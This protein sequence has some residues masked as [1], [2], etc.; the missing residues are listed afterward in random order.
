MDLAEIKRLK[1]ASDVSGFWAVVSLLVSFVLFALAIKFE[2]RFA[3]L[4]GLISA[5]L[6]FCLILITFG[7]NV[8]L[9]VA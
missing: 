9:S 6:T 2:I 3:G 5:T 8:R 7:R 4:V 1:R